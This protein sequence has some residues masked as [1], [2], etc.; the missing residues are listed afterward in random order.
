MLTDR[1]HGCISTQY[2]NLAFSGKIPDAQSH[3]GEDE[4]ILTQDE[5]LAK[6]NDVVRNSSFLNLNSE[7]IARSKNRPRHS[8]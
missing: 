7:K 1:I 5:W 4:R 3:I 8:Y 6:I 2:A